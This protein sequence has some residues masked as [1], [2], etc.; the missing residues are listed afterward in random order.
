MYSFGVVVIEIVSG[1]KSV[2]MQAEAANQYLLELVFLYSFHYASFFF[3]FDELMKVSLVL[4]IIY[5]FE[6]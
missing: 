4:N 6:Q 5:M 3:F 1:R 2:D